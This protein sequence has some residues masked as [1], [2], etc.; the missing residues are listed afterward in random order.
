MQQVIIIQASNN[1]QHTHINYIS[2]NNIQIYINLG[3]RIG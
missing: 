3:R 1:F 2:L